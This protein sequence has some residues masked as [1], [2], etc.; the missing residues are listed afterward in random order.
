M[1]AKMD[2]EIKF[3]FNHPSENFSPCPHAHK[4]SRWRAVTGKK[5]K[6]KNQMLP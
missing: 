5:E 3:L 4:V 6:K 2:F 1:T